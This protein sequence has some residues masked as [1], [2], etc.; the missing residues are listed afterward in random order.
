MLSVVLADDNPRIL[1]MLVELLPPAFSIVAQVDDGE[2]A[3][4]AIKELRPRLAILDISMPKMNGLE[5]AKRLTA[6]KSSTKVV[7]STLLGK[8]IIDEA[9]RW[10]HGYVSKMQMHSD[11][12]P[13][14]EGALRDEF[15]ESALD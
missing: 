4:K 3:L 2:L 11:L 14:I 6:T 5:V 12:L 15:F 10:G 1:K 13:A 7:F 8:E 9:R